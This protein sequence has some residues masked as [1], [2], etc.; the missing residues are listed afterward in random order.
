MF[1]RGPRILD[2]MNGEQPDQI[3]D[4][5]ARPEIFECKKTVTCAGLY[6]DISSSATF[7]RRGSAFRLD[8]QSIPDSHRPKNRRKS[9]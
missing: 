3:D 6:F 7:A 8:A 1:E 2:A 5:I 9:V 4:A